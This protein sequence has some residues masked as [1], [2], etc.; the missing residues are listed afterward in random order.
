M[1]IESHCT[2]FSLPSNPS[3]SPPPPYLS[4]PLAQVELDS[5]VGVDWEPLIRVDRHTEQPRVG[6]EVKKGL[7]LYLEYKYS[8]VQ[9]IYIIKELK[10]KIRFST[11]MFQSF[12]SFLFT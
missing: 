8:Y 2:L 5:G 12:F 1:F 11:T 4:P 6:L 10:K 7:L 9:H 3:Q